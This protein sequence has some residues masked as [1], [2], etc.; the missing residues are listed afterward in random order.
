MK[1]ILP[2]LFVFVIPVLW[3]GCDTDM[4]DMEDMDIDTTMIDTSMMDTTIMDTTMMDTLEWYEELDFITV[5]MAGQSNCDGRCPN[6]GGIITAYNTQVWNGAAWIDAVIGTPP[7]YDDISSYGLAF[8]RRLHEV[9]GKQIRIIKDCYGGNPIENWLPP[10]STNFNAIQT[11]IANSGTEQVDIIAW[12][13]GESNDD[14]FTD[15][16]CNNAVCYEEYFYELISLFRAQDWFDGFFIAGELAYDTDFDGR[17][18][19]IIKL[20]DNYQDLD[21]AATSEDLAKCDY[22]HFSGIAVVHL[23]YYRYF[24]ALKSLTSD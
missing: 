22:A 6:T 1:L 11:Q 24:D 2:I 12:H 14:H 18:D 13:H 4:D 7:F 15:G 9:T 3:V 19:V 5:L 17:N 23:G 10:I 8:A 16:R 20:N 21:A